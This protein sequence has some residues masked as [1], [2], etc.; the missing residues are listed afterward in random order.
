MPWSQ[1][2]PMDQ[3]TQFIA[4]YLRQQLS[5]TD[6]CEHYGISR[7]S[8]YKLIDR[9]LKEG[10]AGLE[11]LHTSRGLVY[12]KQEWLVSERYD[13]SPINNPAPRGGV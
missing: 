11:E 5:M 8:D 10:P 1:T 6:L 13:Q 2:T 12:V 9:S 3:K 4:D 7:K